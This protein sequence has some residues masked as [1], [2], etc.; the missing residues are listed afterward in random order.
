MKTNKIKQLKKNKTVK[1]KL[2]K[3]KKTNKLKKS[4]CRLAD[5]DKYGLG[6]PHL[7]S[8]LEN[9]FECLIAG[10]RNCLMHMYKFV[11]KLSQSIKDKLIK[12]KTKIYKNMIYIYSRYKKHA[13]L[14]YYL[15]ER[16][17]YPNVMNSL[18][19]EGIT[20]FNKSS[21]AQ[22][23][24]L[25]YRQSEIRGFYLRNIALLQIDYEFTKTFVNDDENIKLEEKLVEELK[26]IN[27]P[28][29]NKKYNIMK[30]I[31]DK[32]LK[33]ALGKDSIFNDL[34]EKA[35]IDIKLLEFSK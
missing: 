12:H 19:L 30:S 29:F 8:D 10:H 25:G 15:Q 6:K 11:A 4:E 18:D 28:E 1:I 9:Q 26:K 24:L 34:Y 27:I 20:E 2:L 31:C 35:N 33:M 32:W 17:Q 5:I 21:Y 14:C 22:G 7:S 3:L 16:R 13:I 23:V